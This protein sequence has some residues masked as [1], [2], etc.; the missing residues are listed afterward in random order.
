MSDAPPA[1][2]RLARRS[3]LGQQELYLGDDHLLIAEGAYVESYR[4]IRYKDIE[5]ILIC[6]TSTG[7][8][9]SILSGL[10][11]LVLLPLTVI[12]LG[13][14]PFG[15]AFFG[16]STLALAA[17]A[18]RFLLGRGSAEAG[19]QTAVQTVRLSGISTLRKALQVEQQ[20]A[21]RIEQAQSTLTAE[22]LETV[23]A[24]PAPQPPPVFPPSPAP[25]PPDI[26]PAPPTI[27][28]TP[29]PAS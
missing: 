28:P 7:T 16:A 13:Q 10:G 5:A 6:P 2:T 20:L 12:Q 26:P 27:P 18:A 17:V 29:P 22:E 11:A 15:A 1:Y 23:L 4:K 3:L 14:N 8:I 19:I 24:T 25:A 9:L 21:A